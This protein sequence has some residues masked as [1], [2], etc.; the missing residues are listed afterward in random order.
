MP[1]PITPN[2]KI[3]KLSKNRSRIKNNFGSCT[4][5]GISKKQGSPRK[6]SVFGKRYVT[7]NTNFGKCTLVC[8]LRKKLRGPDRLEKNQNFIIF[9]GLHFPIDSQKQL[10]YQIFHGALLF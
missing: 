5:V 3:K 8:K 4:K 2:Q 6:I 1:P 7:K 9:F 10:A